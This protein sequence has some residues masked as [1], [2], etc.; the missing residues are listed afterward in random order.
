VKSSPE[1]VLPAALLKQVASVSNRWLGERLDMTANIVSS[2]VTT[3]AANASLTLQNVKRPVRDS[4][5]DRQLP[6]R[7]GKRPVTFKPRGVS[8]LKHDKESP[9]NFVGVWRGRS[10]AKFDLFAP[11]PISIR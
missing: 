8:G 10:P 1:K 6:H 4:R 3:S 11:T 5:H 7:L 2:L 9:K